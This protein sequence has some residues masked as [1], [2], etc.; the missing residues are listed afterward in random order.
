MSIEIWTDGSCN[1]NPGPGGWSAIIIDGAEQRELFGGE[2]DVTNNRM[3]LLAV[4][5]GLSAIEQPSHITIFTD[6][7]ITM[8]CALKNWKR[9]AN[10]DLWRQY[11]ELARKH[12]VWFK[13]V[14]GHNGVTLNERADELA[15]RGRL[16]VL[17]ELGESTN[18]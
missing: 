15:N 8:Q 14:K 4:I 16:F 6:S 10:L 12:R 3:E 7:K 5:N 1:P 13:K 11:D 2:H 18:V 17:G 9:G